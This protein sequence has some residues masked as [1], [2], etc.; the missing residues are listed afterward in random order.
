M[1]VPNS[2]P[3]THISLSKRRWRRFCRNRRGFYSL[4]IFGSLFFLSL[5]AEAIS[6]DVPLLVVYEGEN[7]FPLFVEY[8]ETTFGGDF[9]TE[10]DYLDPYM[11]ELMS[12]GEK[13]RK[14]VV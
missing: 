4:L 6:N 14:S 2:S 8:P 13:D 1:T 12:S 11:A 5:F 7:Y 9:E 10:T 3:D